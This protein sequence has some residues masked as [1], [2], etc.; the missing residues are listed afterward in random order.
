L[1]AVLRERFARTVDRF[2]PSASRDAPEDRRRA[3]FAV[4]MALGLAPIMAALAA[5]QLAAGHPEGAGGSAALGAVLVAAP[6][7]YR[8]WPRLGPVVHGGL[9][10]GW[11]ALVA[12][13]VSSRGAGINAAGVGLAELPLF[14]VLL[15]GMRGGVAWAAVVCATEI[16][17]AGVSSAGHLIERVPPR[18][19]PLVEYSA[20]III[21]L[22]LFAVGVMYEARRDQALAE[23]VEQA[24]ALRAAE[25]K[26]VEAETDARL[27]HAERLASIGRVTA[28]VA[29]EINNPLS[30]LGM[31]LAFVRDELGGP[32]VDAEEVAR[33]L[34]DSIVGVSQIG[35][36]VARLRSHASADPD[37]AG[38]GATSLAAAIH[39]AVEVVR[40]ASRGRAE[41][42]CEI[43]VLPPARGQEG[44]LVQVLVNLI[45]NAVQAAPEGRAAENLIVVR[46][47]RQGEWLAV[48]VCDNGPGIPAEVL[49]RV[50]E[51]FFTTR[52][53]GEGSG[54][55][56]AV[57]KSMIRAIGGKL[58]IESEP[59]RTIFRVLLPAA[60]VEQ[61]AIPRAG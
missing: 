38:S 36:L 20:L 24:R 53:I 5:I 9:S 12:I 8:R 34:T 48:E 11:L 45:T 6:F 10:C 28:A 1:A 55:G 44:A 30:Y 23:A 61:P 7:A 17:L 49:P 22:T 26:Q 2:V 29:H 35:Q 19:L 39:R 21:T 15:T 57:S 60:T 33:A 52:P 47:V 59:G 46:A 16:G 50:G 51:P 42:R 40:P 18:G 32:D 25:R 13:T 14:A 37:S 54:L 4:G 43:D 56:L 41:L 27:A 3:R 31:N 58:E